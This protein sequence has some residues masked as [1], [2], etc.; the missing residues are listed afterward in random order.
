MKQ[1][2][3]SSLFLFVIGVIN[4]SL[5]QDSTI[6]KETVQLSTSNS[7][8]YCTLEMKGSYDQHP[9]A[10]MTMMNFCS[11]NNIEMMPAGIYWNSPTDTKPEDLKWELAVW[12]PNEMKVD[13]PLKVKKW[14]YV[15]CA[16]VDFDGVYLSETESKIINETYE[17]ISNNGYSATGPLVRKYLNQPVQNTEGQ[18]SG[19]VQVIIPVQ[20]KQ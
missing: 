4:Y 12:I 14:E 8:Y 20:K 10:F 6:T 5:A 9:D 17:W 2:K 11:S 15:L 19:K 18:W 13:E 1:I 3:L 7:F 16:N